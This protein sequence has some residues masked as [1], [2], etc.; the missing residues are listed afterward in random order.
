M[1]APSSSSRPRRPSWRAG[2]AEIRDELRADRELAERVA[3]KFEIKN[4]MGYRLCAFLD[5]DEPLEIFR[6]LVIGSEGTLAFVAE[7][8]FETVPFGSHATVALV[9]LRATRRRRRARSATWSSSGA[10]AT[11]LMI[12]PTL[13]AAAFNMPG[14]PERWKTLPPEAAALLV[15]FRGDEAGELDEPERRA[16]EFLAGRELV[17]EPRFSRDRDEIEMLWHV[18]EGMQGLV[19]GIPPA[20]RGADHRGRVRA[21]G[22]P[23]RGRQGPAGAARRARLPAGRSPATPRP[24]TSTSC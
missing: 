13:I 6:R 21:A 9:L 3:R 12:A 22:A 15:E 23:R 1:P 11:E 14:T 18:R 7:A 17:D 19:G 24:A 4:T 5:A 20:R 2:L 8:V 10:S 16:L